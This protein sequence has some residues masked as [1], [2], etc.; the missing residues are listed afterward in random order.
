[1]LDK[2]IEEIKRDIPNFSVEIKEDSK[3]MQALAVPVSLF[4]E[5]FLS[6][7]ITTIYPKVFFPANSLQEEL[8]AFNV[9]A[10]EW[11]HLRQAKK[12]G[13]IL[14]WFKYLF[15]QSLSLLALFAILAPLTPYALLCLCFLVFLAPMPAPWRAKAEME[16]YAMSLYVLHKEKTLSQIEIEEY[17]QF[18]EKEFVG[19][20]YYFM[21]PFAENFSEKFDQKIEKII[22]GKYD[23]EYPFSKIS[24]LISE[25]KK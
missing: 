1:M 17:K 13:V 4:N 19:H 8:S 14:A 12:D 9:L 23:Q 15:P 11:I 25:R 3:L 16:A 10:H 7:Y 24:E 18:L 6:A 21:W 20:A 2:L 5:R 22:S